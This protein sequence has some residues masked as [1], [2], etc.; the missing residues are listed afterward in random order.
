MPKMNSSK[1]LIAS[2]LL[3]LIAVIVLNHKTFATH[4]CKNITDLDDQAE[5]YAKEIEEKEEEYEST[6]K[7]LDE[8]R[9]TKDSIDAK[10][11]LYLSELSVTQT[12]IDEL[13]SEIDHTKNEIN[14]INELLSDRRGQ[15]N[16][17]ITLRNLAVRNYLKR[18]FRSDLEMFFAFDGFQYATLTYVYNK[19]VSDDSLK[20]IKLLNSEIDTYETDKKEAE[21][22]KAD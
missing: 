4:Q 2:L 1:H 7:K 19:S 13:Q 20:L 9:A 8:I 3:T 18:D 11:G 14:T 16:K 10:I 17:K 15:L 12:Q 5:C 21:N 6:S 22:L